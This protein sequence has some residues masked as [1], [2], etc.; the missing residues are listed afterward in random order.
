M[1]HP[2]LLQQVI[3]LTLV[4]LMLTGCVTPG[5]IPVSELPV[6]STVIPTSE[7]PPA[8]PT[9]LPPT[10]TPTPELLNLQINATFMVDPYQVKLLQVEERPS[11]IA[12]TSDKIGAVDPKQ[13][14]SAWLVVTIEIANSG[15]ETS[16]LMLLPSSATVLEADGQPVEL[17]SVG[18]LA[19]EDN[20]LMLGFIEGQKLTRGFVGMGA[21]GN[22]F[23]I[24][25]NSQNL[26]LGGGVRNI[27]G[28]SEGPQWDLGNL[29]PEETTQ[30]S[31]LFEVPVGASKLSWHFLGSAPISLPEAQTA[32]LSDER[33]PGMTIG[34]IDDELCQIAEVLELECP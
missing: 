18:I 29:P 3:T 24:P 4:M 20:G 11:I 19:P 22:I 28:D 6:P 7:P 12:L 34:L 25:E 9:P 32:A 16:P 2:K 21:S 31:L 30:L 8:T 23:V 33:G 27:I 13:D 17:S 10:T 15:N 1:S 26:L 5:V 14:G